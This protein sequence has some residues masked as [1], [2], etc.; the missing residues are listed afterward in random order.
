MSD[1]ARK[2]LDFWKNT[3]LPFNSTIQDAITNLE[4]FS[5]QIVLVVGKNGELLGTISDG[6]IRRGL[7]QEKVIND[8]ISSII[9]SKPFVVPI[10]VNR[11]IVLNIMEI[12]KIHQVPIVDADNKVIGLHL[13]DQVVN[14]IN[15]PN[16][17]VIMAGGVGSRMGSHT[18]SCPKPMLELRGRPMLE[19]IIERAKLEG[20]KRFVISLNY[21]GRMIEDYFGSGEDFN[22]EIEYTREDSPLG[23][24][25]A[26]SLINP[27][28]DEPFVITN[29]DV[30]SDIRYG[31][32]LDFHKQNNAAATM[33]V[34]LQEWQNPFG[35][36]NIDELKI[37]GFTEK[38]VDRS[39]INAGVYV[40]EPKSL[41]SLTY[42]SVC[43]MPTLF[44]RLSEK[45]LMTIAY[46]MHEEWLDVGR[47]YDYEQAENSIT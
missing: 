37:T 2:A 1:Q 25:G 36:V 33:A 46:A 35:V 21:L 47:P 8:P 5:M 19:H 43:D 32:V 22:V 40:L 38:P 42:G 28:P 41:A 4:R 3:V 6:D 11:E 10:N 13:W 12:N 27:I 14:S 29:G 15:R 18:E 31:K 30:I 39:Y 26:L 34:R 17:M 16:L 7:L 24:A 20:F 9:H 44:Q 45:G 23:T